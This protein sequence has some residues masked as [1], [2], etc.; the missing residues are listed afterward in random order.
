MQK[1][2]SGKTCG[3][4]VKQGTGREQPGKGVVSGESRCEEAFLSITH[5]WRQAAGPLLVS[6]QLWPGEGACDSWLGQCPSA[7]GGN[8]ELGANT[9]EGHA[10]GG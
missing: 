2:C 4:E 1:C 5:I 8:W 10:G 6:Y 3:E 9:G 7:D